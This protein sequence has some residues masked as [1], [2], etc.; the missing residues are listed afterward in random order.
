MHNFFKAKKYVILACIAILLILCTAYQLK[1]IGIAA[2]EDSNVIE[3]AEASENNISQ[4]LESISEKIPEENTTEIAEEI[5]N[6]E[7]NTSEKYEEISKEVVSIEET[8][9]E[10]IIPENNITEEVIT[11]EATAEEVITEKTTAEE[12]I[13]K[14]ENEETDITDSTKDKDD[15]LEQNLKNEEIAKIPTELIFDNEAYKITVSAVTEGAL[16]NIRNVEVT[17]ITTENNAEEYNDILYKLNQKVE[18]ENKDNTKKLA[19]FLAYDI[20]LIDDSENEKEPDGNV[21][22]SIEYKELPDLITQNS[23]LEVSVIHFDN[24][25]NDE[26]LVEYSQEEENLT[27][28]KDN[29][30]QITKLE[31]KTDSFSFFTITW[32]IDA[33]RSANIIVHYVDSKGKDIQGSITEDINVS[34]DDII[35]LSSYIGTIDNYI[36][37]DSHYKSYDGEL[38]TSIGFKNNDIQNTNVDVNLYYKTEIVETFELDDKNKTTNIDLYLVYSR[39]GNLTI[40]NDIKN[41]GVLKAILTDTSGND[42]SVQNDT[43]SLVWYKS[44]TE[45]GPYSEVSR[46]AIANLSDVYNISSD[47]TEINV[48][49]DQGARKYYKVQLI[50]SEGNVLATSS[51]VQVEYYADVQNGGFENPN[52]KTGYYGGSSWRAKDE[53]GVIRTDSVIKQLVNGTDGLIWKTTGSDGKIELGRN[54][55]NDNKTLK[56]YYNNPD[57]AAEGEQFAELNC[58]EAGALYQDVLTVPGEVLYWSLYHRGRYGGEDT[59]YGKDT[60]YVVAI[61]TEYAENITSYD[62]VKA[63][64]ENPIEYPGAYCYEITD[65]NTAWKKHSGSF[66][67]P[68]NQYLTRF[69]FVAGQ[70][71]TGSLTEGNLLDDIVLSQNI[72]SEPESGESVIT[73]K[74]VIN[75]VPYSIKDVQKTSL[76]IVL[77]DNKNNILNTNDQKFTTFAY[78]K[79]NQVWFA[80]KTITISNPE[81]ISEINITESNFAKN[82]ANYDFYSSSYILTDTTLSENIQGSGLTVNDENNNI[83]A[84]GTLSS[85]DT[86]NTL[87]YGGHNYTLTIENNYMVTN[88]NLIINKVNIFGEKVKGSVF[89][90]YEAGNSDTDAIIITDSSDESD[91][92]ILHFS[93]LKYN[94]EYIIEEV[95]A[96]NN[97]YLLENPI[98]II[99]YSSTGVQILNSSDFKDGY[100]TKTENTTNELDVVNV[101]HVEMPKAGGIGNYKIYILGIFIMVNA[102]IIYIKLKK[103]IIN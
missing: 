42:L 99:I 70:T 56:A 7:E 80:I 18:S 32:T 40:E 10:E 44:D 43:S 87:L 3:I 37:R 2:E 51:P 8:I 41:N 65:D 72:V 68:E 79:T 83:A 52:I 66:V 61:A 35:N 73:I 48:A 16:K 58:E 14:I 1:L 23:N 57:G 78:D 82:I 81:S 50:N 36:Y 92:G 22:V 4:K 34:L 31:F 38:I 39:V 33:T 27:I 98:H 17:P 97:Y 11:E 49:L 26:K 93:N 64:I 60:M 84:T 94:T 74:K 62:Q 95:T 53:D 77:S 54:G 75:N 30:N 5:S 63:I 89:K 15:T 59:K 6:L 69:F 67:I 90:I 47:G 100:V 9:T 76:N 13:I 103:K 28:E 25:N 101:K 12:S 55:T 88:T 45:N 85:S 96:P 71:A 20:K 91:D 29:G 21:N 46:V 102:T 86:A 24:S 19:G